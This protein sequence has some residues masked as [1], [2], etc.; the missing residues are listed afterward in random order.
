MALLASISLN[1]MAS[2]MVAG[3]KPWRLVVVSAV[4][5]FLDVSF[6]GGDDQIGHGFDECLGLVFGY[7]C[8]LGC[9]D[10]VEQRDNGCLIPWC[11]DWVFY[12]HGSSFTVKLDWRTL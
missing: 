7:L 3:A 5:V 2:V 11:N 12:I 9:V 1:W 8:A 10:G 6:Q 4:M